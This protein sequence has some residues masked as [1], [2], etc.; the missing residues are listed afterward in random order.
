[1]PM[2]FVGPVG[3]DLGADPAHESIGSCPSSS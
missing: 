2:G 3:A 1:L